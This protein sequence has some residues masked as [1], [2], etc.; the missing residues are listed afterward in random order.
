MKCARFVVPASLVVLLAT[1][2]PALAK[3]VYLSCVTV[4]NGASEK[5]DLTADEEAGTV[6]VSEPST[7][8]NK[9]YKAAFSRNQVTFSDGVLFDYSINRTD[10][11]ITVKRMYAGVAS[12]KCQLETPPKR[13]F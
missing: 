3:P 1:A 12:G 2:H 5:F 7:G 6:A 13:A 8:F 10:L 11:S 4:E 9:S